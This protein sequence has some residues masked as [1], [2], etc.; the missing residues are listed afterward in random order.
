MQRLSDD[1]RNEL[2]RQVLVLYEA[3]TIVQHLYSPWLDDGGVCNALAAI[4]HWLGEAAR[5]GDRSGLPPE[6]GLR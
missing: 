1:R 2:R 5:T 4:E 6:V 3:R